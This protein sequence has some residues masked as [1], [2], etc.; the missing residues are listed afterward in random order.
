MENTQIEVALA[1][2]Y[3]AAYAAHVGAGQD[4]R[5]ARQAAQIACGDFTAVVEGIYSGEP[6]Q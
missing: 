1:R 6:R 4:S 3:A 2:V 5:S